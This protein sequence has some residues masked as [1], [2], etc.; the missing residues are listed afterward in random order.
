MEIYPAIDIRA[1]RSVRLL[2]GAFDAETVYD[3]DPLAVARTYAGAGATWIHVVD[4]DA[5]RTG[6]AVHAAQV[7][8]ICAEVSCSVQV[9]GGVR[10]REAAMTLLDAGVTRVVV[11]TAAV[12]DPDWV[13]ALCASHPGAVGIGLDARGSDIA[14]HGWETSGGVDL[15]EA[16]ARWSDAGAGAV[17]VTEIDRDGTL[18]GPDLDQLGAVLAVTEVPVIASGGVGSLDDLRAL[19]NLSV[20]GRRPAG[21]IVGRALADGRFTLGEALAVTRDGSG[22]G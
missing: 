20:E 18:E 11:G 10:T 1:G 13:V 9:G 22:A 16:C 21:A 14:I 4:L 7:A 15:L 8:A 12:T 17:I 19:G 5:A 3:D 6:V 2:R